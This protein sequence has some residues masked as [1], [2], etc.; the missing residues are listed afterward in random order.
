MALQ[1]MTDEEDYKNYHKAKKKKSIFF[2]DFLRAKQMNPLILG[3]FYINFLFFLSKE[4]K[5][6]NSDAKFSIL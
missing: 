2:S 4:K 3:S 6:K 5:K 1:A